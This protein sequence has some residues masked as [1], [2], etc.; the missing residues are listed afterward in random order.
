ML[1]IALEPR[2]ALAYNNLGN[3]LVTGQS[4]GGRGAAPAGA[5]LKPD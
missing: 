2:H 3:A 1:A 5:E 4:A